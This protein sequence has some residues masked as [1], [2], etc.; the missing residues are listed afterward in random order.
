M[1]GKLQIRQPDGPEHDMQEPLTIVAA[2]GDAEQVSGKLKYHGAELTVSSS[3]VRLM[4][5]ALIGC[6]C[7]GGRSHIV[8]SHHAK[9]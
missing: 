6:T 1:Q 3:T 8:V 2:M 9:P 5:V 7:S 4:Y